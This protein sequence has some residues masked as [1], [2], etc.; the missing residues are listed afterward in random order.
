MTTI[1]KTAKIEAERRAEIAAKFAAMTPAE[2]AVDLLDAQTE[3]A[4]MDHQ[5]R[6][7][8]KDRCQNQ[9]FDTQYARID[10]TLTI[11]RAELAARTTAK[12]A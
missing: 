5:R 3:L 2:I 9:W 10:Q 8:P 6:V 4:L 12:A 7:S 11:A 1:R